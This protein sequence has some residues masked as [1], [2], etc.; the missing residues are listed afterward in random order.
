MRLTFLGTSAGAPTLERN[1][2]ALAL[3]ID[4]QKE[5]YLVDCGEGTQHRL[6]R[7]RYTLSGLKTIFITHVHGDHMFGLPGLITTASMQ[8]RKE[9]LTICAP[10][11]VESFVRHALK[12]AD[13]SQ[14]PF[15][16]RFQATDVEGFAYQDK[17]LAVTA[18]ELSHRVPSYAYRFAECCRPGALD[19]DRLNELGVPRGRLWGELQSGQSVTLEDGRVIEPEQV[20]Q[21]PEPARIVVIGGDN[22]KPALL[23]K[24]LQGAQLLVH[25]ATFTEDVFQK[26]GPKY[27]HSTAKM[28]AEAAEQAGIDHVILTHISGRYRRKPKA[29]EYGVELLRSEA[30]QYF[31]GAVSLAEDWGCW[32]LFRD[33]RLEQIKEDK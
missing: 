1:V 4:E 28:V 8:G 23:H 2:T 19:Q 16:L 30:K 22:D 26:V 17:Q 7:S 20:R 6:M 29:G 31:R 11:G 18:H 24:A 21:P 27:M 15:S 25:E 10:D 12:C 5:W 14:L 33:G 32:Q 3:A 13:V 9:P